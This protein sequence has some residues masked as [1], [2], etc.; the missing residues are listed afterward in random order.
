MTEQVKRR[1]HDASPLRVIEQKDLP[2]GSS[3][4][5]NVHD[6]FESIGNLVF[7]TA[8]DEQRWKNDTARRMKKS[9]LAH[10]IGT[11]SSLL[12]S[13]VVA[14]LWVVFWG[15]VFLAY[16]LWTGNPFSLTDSVPGRYFISC[17]ICVVV[18]AVLSYILHRVENT[19]ERF[20]PKGSYQVLDLDH[21]MFPKDNLIDQHKKTIFD[22]RYNPVRPTS[23]KEQ[24]SRVEAATCSPVAFETGDSSRRLVNEYREYI[25]MGN[26]F[27]HSWP[28]ASSSSRSAIG[29]R[30]RTQLEKVHAAWSDYENDVNEID[31]VER[32]TRR[33]CRG[34][35]D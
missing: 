17:S 6:P 3:S 11:V 25:E 32:E 18:A 14:C 9:Q 15:T 28:D 29:D 16:G 4:S 33:T 1:L 31:R 2:T 23:L 24:R 19:V 30:L 26:R 21:P 5:G 35:Y 7:A 27:A 10:R 8:E 34:E 20:A 22:L 12:K 13:T